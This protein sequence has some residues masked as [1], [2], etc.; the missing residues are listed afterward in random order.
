MKETNVFY[1]LNQLPQEE[2]LL[3]MGISMNRIGN[4]QSADQCF[5]DIEFMTSKIKKTD[6]IGLVTLYS[7]YLYFHSDEPAKTLRDR[8]KDLM[9]QH[10]NGFLSLLSHSDVWFVKKA[11]SF[12]TMG[13]MMLDNA[14]EFSAA[15]QKVLDLYKCDAKFAECVAIDAAG[16]NH[17]LGSGE[18]M[19][20]LEEITLFYLAAK[21]KL[22]FNNRFVSGTE[23]W[24]LFMY[25]GKPLKSE[26]YL[27]QTN[28]LK[29]SNPQNRFE[30]A[31][32]DLEGRTLYEYDRI[33]LDTFNF[34]D[35]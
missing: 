34:A 17:G 1:D 20:I 31:F 27:F 25:P 5:A 35:A 24:T 11:F 28:P 29:L 2:G 26:V 12:S 19:F 30:N 23:K 9:F 13:Q 32:Y 21:G 14:T 33:D 8:Y 7:D 10:K 16:A 22:S 18:L 6:G 15:L 4:R 3:L